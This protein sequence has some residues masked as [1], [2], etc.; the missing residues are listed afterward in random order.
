MQRRV[1]SCVMT[2]GHTLIGKVF[3]S[4]SAVDKGFVRRVAKRISAAGFGV[5]LD[6]YEL[7]PGDRL[8]ETIADA[9]AKAKVVIVV[10][11]AASI[12]SR[13]LR[14]ELN[15]AAERMVKGECRVIPVVIGDCAVPSS[16]DGLLYADF[17]TSFA[18]GMKALMNALL[19]EAN[20]AVAASGFR[21]QARQVVEEVFETYGWVS[22]MGDFDNRTH[23]IVTV[24]VA[25]QSGDDTPVVFDLVPTEKFR[26]AA[27]GEAWWGEYTRLRDDNDEDLFLVVTER[28]VTIDVEST[29]A[30]GGCVK[31][32]RFTKSVADHNVGHV[33]FA[34]L[35]TTTGERGRIAIVRAA[36]KLLIALAE[37]ISRT[38]CA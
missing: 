7:R 9:L 14:F 1:E 11:S 20:R 26:N 17:R 29:R 4:H 32:K 19:H 37:K 33:V 23:D 35:S 3:I 12:R 15:L 31:Y 38:A 25:G 36:R 18:R 30:P 16:V 2:T 34:D 24:G 10:V 6:E 5:W 21:A 8:T 27:I 28:P 13:W 22:R